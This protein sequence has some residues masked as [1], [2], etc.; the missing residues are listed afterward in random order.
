MYPLVVFTIGISLVAFLFS[1]NVYPHAFLK[2]RTLLHDI[3]RKKPTAI[4]IGGER[5]EVSTWKKVITEIMN[6]CN[7]DAEKHVELMNL[8]GKIAGRE[9]VILSK[10][11]DKMRSPLKIDENL[12]LETHYDTETLLRTTITRILDVVR[13]NYHDIII[14]T[15]RKNI[16]Y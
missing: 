15:L 16:V 11:D 12:Y 2:Y 10:T 9:R 4:T 3:Q 1:N 14:T 6:H 7:N 5:I 8:R 13:Y